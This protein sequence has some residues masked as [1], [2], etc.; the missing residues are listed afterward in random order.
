MAKVQAFINDLGRLPG[1]SGYLL[2]GENG[3]P[4]GETR[5]DGEQI[6]AMLQV[7]LL[8]SGRIREILGLARL[9]HL[10]IGDQEGGRLLVF[11]LGRFLLGVEQAADRPGP[12]LAR[13]ILDLIRS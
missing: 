1:V 8:A 12:D 9:K 5:A 10:S 4:L 2:I 11:P 13:E 7:V 6:G 3:R